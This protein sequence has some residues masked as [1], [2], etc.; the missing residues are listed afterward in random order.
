M[1]VVARDDDDNRCRT[2]GKPVQTLSFLDLQFRHA[3]AGGDGNYGPDD[4]EG[5]VSLLHLLD[6]IAWDP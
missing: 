4:V 2:T 1:S 3:D 6:T 5:G